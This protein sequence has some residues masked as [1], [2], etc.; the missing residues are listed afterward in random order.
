MLFL[1]LKLS[2]L[3][4]IIA[5]IFQVEPELEFALTNS[6]RELEVIVLASH[7]ANL[8]TRSDYHKTLMRKREKTFTYPHNMCL[9]VKPGEGMAM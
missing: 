2:I 1:L 8:R 6:P 5:H 9:L 3:L 7:S 4:R